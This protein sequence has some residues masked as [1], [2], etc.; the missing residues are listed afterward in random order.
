MKKSLLA[1]LAACV[2]MLGA[3]SAAPVKDELVATIN[4]NVNFLYPGRGTT[5]E[6]YNFG[7]LV[8]N[9]LVRI[10]EDLKLEPE[11]ATSWSSDPTGSEWTF[12]LRHDVKFH[13]GQPFTAKDVVH[14]FALLADPAL[15]SRARSTAD[16]V[17]TMETPDPYTV[18]FVLK[19]PY[20]A[21]PDMLIERQLKIVPDGVSLEEMARTPVGTEIGRAHV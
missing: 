3:A 19:E 18:K 21:W 16:M 1:G 9:G 4:S 13:N 6:E 10:N 8:F 17:Q 12:Q 5:A 15:A 14:T 20:G 11:L 7:M 2:L